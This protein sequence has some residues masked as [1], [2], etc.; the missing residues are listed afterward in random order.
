MGAPVLGPNYAIRVLFCAHCQ[1][2]REQVFQVIGSRNGRDLAAQC[3]CGRTLKWPLTLSR[4]ELQRAFDEHARVNLGQ[5]LAEPGTFFGKDPP[6]ID[7]PPAD[8]P[9]AALAP[10]FSD[11]NVRSL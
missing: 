3:K 4:E 9:L 2:L 11:N 1:A 8:E 5:A 6:V 7:P 10:P